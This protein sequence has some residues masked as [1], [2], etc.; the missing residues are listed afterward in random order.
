VSLYRDEAARAITPP[1]I[2]RFNSFS[3]MLSTIPSFIWYHLK[4]ITITIFL[5]KLSSR[6]S[7]SPV[8]F[9]LIHY[10]ICFI[11]LREVHLDVFLVLNVEIKF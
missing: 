1:T 6:Q 5:G 8:C 11:F 7:W 3:D 9:A 10:W 4:D 2:V